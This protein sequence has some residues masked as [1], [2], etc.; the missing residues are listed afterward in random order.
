MTSESPSHKVYVAVHGGAGQH[1]RTSEYSDRIK[2]A[3]KRACTEALHAA[4][5]PGADALSMVEHAIA[6][7]EDEESMNAGY[8]S[9]LTFDGTVECD[10]AIMDGK[11]G[12]FGSAGAV[13]GVKNPIKLAAAILG[14]SREPDRLGRIRPLTLVAA[15][16]RSFAQSR[17]LETVL[18]DT[19]VSPRAREDWR[20]WM[21]RYD[22]ANAAP[23]PAVSALP[24]DASAMQDTVGAVAWDSDGN[25]AAGVSREPQAATYGAGCWAEQS[26]DGQTGMAISGAGEHI[27]RTSLARTIADVLRPSGGDTDVDVHD[28]LTRTL[29]EQFHSPTQARDE[30]HPNAGVLLMT[31]EGRDDGSIIPRL[32]CAFTTESMAIA[33]GSSDN[34]APKAKILRRPKAARTTLPTHASPVYITALPFHG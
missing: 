20:R 11:R 26:P 9:N 19:M 32:W 3:M 4:S 16:A 24:Q 21:A 18:P 22:E 27:M 10:A 5:R 2:S 12:D 33:Y 31:K 6:T 8:G 17:S 1:N 15:G 25:L 23:G 29:V 13:T 34:P 30:A 28:I 14:H 7:L